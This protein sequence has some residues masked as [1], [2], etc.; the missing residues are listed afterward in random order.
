MA[1]RSDSSGPEYLDM[2]ATTPVDPRVAELVMHH[3]VDDFGNAGSRTHAYGS[4][5]AK[6]VEEARR[7]VS[8]VVDS[9]PSDVIFTSGATEADNLATLGLESFGREQGRM[10]IV[11]SAIEHKAVLEPLAEMEKRGFTVDFVGSDSSGTVSA[12]EVLGRVRGDTLLVSVM[13][14]NNETGVIQPIAEIAEALSGLPVFLHTDAA[15][16]FGKEIDSLRHP[17]IDLISVSGHKIFAPKGVGALIARRRDRERP[18]VRPLMFGGGQERGL[19]PGTSPVA[20]IAGFGLASE[21]AR[22]ESKTRTASCL[23]MRGQFLDVLDR[24][25]A[26]V[27]GDPD[28]SLASIVNFSVPGADSEAVILALRDVAAISNGSACTSASYQPSHVLTAMGLDDDRRRGAVRASW[29]HLSSLPD[30]DE[31]VAALRILT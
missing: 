2:A 11:A 26:V 25:G 20:L 31:I 6:A 9:D 29:S 17:R 15:Q 30:S 14:V 28:R 3:L 13:H 18:P 16:G 24:V 22:T 7:R 21:L 27:N 5:A 19:R 4:S 23:A 10:H 8:D 12:D 1:T